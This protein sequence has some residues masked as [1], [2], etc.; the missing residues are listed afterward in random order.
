MY[1]T[2]HPTGVLLGGGY[3]VAG[4]LECRERNETNVQLRI[5]RNIQRRK[6]LLR[7]G[8]EQTT[9]EKVKGG[10][11]PD[12]KFTAPPCLSHPGY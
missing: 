12:D 6:F 11:L 9:S 5:A 4:D 10:E 3:H 1:C 2:K 8:W 7:E